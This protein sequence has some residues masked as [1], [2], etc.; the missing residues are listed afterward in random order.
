MN[1]IIKPRAPTLTESLLP[2]VTMVLL[3]GIGY[4]A[5]DLPPDMP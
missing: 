5:F 4:A 3:L 2:I 1:N